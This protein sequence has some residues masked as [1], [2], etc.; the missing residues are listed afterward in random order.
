MLKNGG[1]VILLSLCAFVKAQKPLYSTAKIKQIDTSLEEIKKQSIERQKRIALFA[2]TQNLELKQILPNGQVKEIEDIDTFG[3]P[4]YR[5]SEN[6]ID[7]GKTTSTQNLHEGGTLGLNLTGNYGRINGRLG[8]WDGG[9]ILDTHT[10]FENR[11][12]LQDNAST[13]SAHATHVAGTM[14]GAGI[15]K[16][17]KGMAFGAQLKAW[18][19]TNDQVEMLA[20]AKDLLVSNH[21]Y[22]TVAG[23]YFNENRTTP[24]KWEWQGNLSIS[25]DEDYRLGQ[26]DASAQTWDRIMYNAPYYLIVKSAGNKRN[27]NGPAL[28]ATDP[29]QTVEKYFIGNTNDSSRVARYRNNAYDILPTYSCAKNILTVGA[30]NII[31]NGSKNNP[32]IRISNFSSWGPTDDGRIKPDIVGA[33]VNLLSSVST[34]PTSYGFLSGTSMSS[35]QVSGSL[36]LLQELFAKNNSDNLLIS[37]ALKGLACHTA[38]DAGRPGPDYI[39]GWGLLNVEEAAKVILNTNGQYLL[40][41]NNLN[42]GAT[43]T[44]KVIAKGTEPLKIT[45]CWT[46]PEASPLPIN[47]D[48]LDNP[49]PMLINDLDIKVTDT[50]GKI[51][52]AW[53]MNPSKP[54]ENASTGDNKLDN[55]EQV[56]IPTTIP[57]NEY[58]VTISHKSTLKNNVQQYALIMSGVGGVAYCKS[59]PISN[60]NTKI[61]AVKIENIDYTAGPNCTDY[62]DKT[63]QIVKIVPG[64]ATAFEVQ[65]G[66]CASNKA[67]N[68]AAYVDLNLDGDFTD[69][70]ENLYVTKTV[71]DGKIIGT[72]SLPE[73]INKGINT[74][75]RLVSSEDAENKPCGNYSAGETIDFLMTTVFAQKDLA[76]GLLNYPNINNCES[77]TLSNVIIEIENKG[78]NT[79]ANAN[80][81]LN[82]FEENVSIVKTLTNKKINLLG[83]TKTNVVIPINQIVLKKDKNYS[84]NFAIEDSDEIQTN[85]IVQINAKI[86]APANAQ[87]AQVIDCTKSNLVTLSST[88][89]D[90]T[91]WYDAPL[92]GNLIATGTKVQ[93]PKVGL[94]A[95]LYAV[96]NNLNAKNIG[97]KTKSVFG[98]GNYSGNFGPKV[99]IS[100]KVPTKIESARLYIGTSGRL[101][102]NVEKLPNGEIVSSSTIDVTSFRNPALGGAATNGLFAD[103]PNDPG[104]VYNLNLEMPS[105]GDYQIG[106]E[107][108]DGA[109]IFRSNIAVPANFYP[110]NIQNIVTLKG[111]FFNNAI[112]T[113][114][115][116]Y[117]YDIKL[118]S[119]GCTSPETV[120]A[121]KSTLEATEAI[122]NASKLNICKGEK[123]NISGANTS[124]LNFEWFKDS[125]LITNAKTNTIVASETGSYFAIISKNGNCPSKSN[126]L[127]LALKSPPSP[128]VSSIGNQITASE[129]ENY[130]W[131]F[132][133]KPL[134]GVSG[135][136]ISA[137]Q[138]GYYSVVAKVDGCEL[139]SPE[140]YL[141]ILDN[142]KPQNVISRIYPN[143][144][145]EDLVIDISNINI[146]KNT[147]INIFD[148]KG[149]LKYQ[150]LL[151]PNQKQSQVNVKNFERGMYFIWVESNHNKMVG[152]FLKID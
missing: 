63:D 54:D 134:D 66:T 95:N 65:I 145:S 56:Y 21:S 127:K 43:Y 150:Q 20:A 148:T 9:K 51:H 139:A 23:W 107:Y 35:P 133:K 152:K 18:D 44:K 2:K 5:I 19:F 129:A 28:L 151:K 88:N 39:Y 70:N 13:L 32:D 116:Y 97:A 149:N 68:F 83:L 143:P 40:E 120:L 27:E 72:I 80:I 78:L 113:S 98:G 108:L 49:T 58:T 64:K 62:T 101:K 33:G 112:V 50:K 81:S 46:D 87:N 93:I 4:V 103:D 146:L 115:Y 38:N 17:A 96:Q 48:I 26:Y 99:L 128:T 69:P 122:I 124:D 15:N 12:S 140:I 91:F 74:I 22:G 109:S 102:F 79:I 24:Q 57:G 52:Q 121:V 142:E 67:T 8:I 11:I 75:L 82:I 131:Y 7:A 100:T 34:N 137:Y 37:S 53:I 130:T 73:Q 30:I 16:L 10:E 59:S 141:T 86:K 3:L 41:T 123:V 42:N 136:V 114:A 117:F 119:L 144:T 118:K 45:I 31:A 14:I 105:A 138:T 77:D 1:I 76:V 84:Y 29:T 126:T 132:N 36:F 106:I 92:N 111:S 6:N 94:P 135:R 47:K 125:V 25:Q 55:V 90:P 147:K 110:I 104:A 71:I 89:S 60:A 61:N 85:N